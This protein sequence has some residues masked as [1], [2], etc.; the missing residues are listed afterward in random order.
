MPVTVEGTRA[1]LPRVVGVAGGRPPLAA[2]PP[3]ARPR[4]PLPLLAAAERVVRAGLVERVVLLR[5][6]RGRIALGVARLVLREEERPLDRVVAP[7]AGRARLVGAAAAVGLAA[8]SLLLDSALVVEAVAA[9]LAAAAALAA[10][11]GVAEGT[12]ALVGDGVEE[13]MAGG[14]GVIGAGLAAA[15]AGAAPA[16]RLVRVRRGEERTMAERERRRGMA[17]GHRGL[18]QERTKA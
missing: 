7:A 8:A 13:V 4:P 16:G 1:A 3:A 14:A 11:A 17:A 18:R 10:V 12:A 9:G 5:V 15:A 2:R 6:A